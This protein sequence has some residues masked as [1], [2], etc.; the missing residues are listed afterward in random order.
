MKRSQ[1]YSFGEAIRELFS[2]DADLHE[3]VLEQ[4]A[5]NE[6][7]NVLGPVMRYVTS[8]KISDGVLTLRVSSPA[9]KQGILLDR[10]T[11]I[12][13][14]NDAIDAELLRELVVY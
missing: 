1:T 7:A 3:G 9:V 8:S 4:R 11:L 5:L 2:E 13:R 12:R 6:L 14:L 10:M